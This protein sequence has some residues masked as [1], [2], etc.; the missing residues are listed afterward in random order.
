[1]SCISFSKSGNPQCHVIGWWRVDN[2]KTGGRPLWGGDIWTGIWMYRGSQSFRD[3]GKECFRQ[4][5]EQVWMLYGGNKLGAWKDRKKGR[6]AELW[7]GEGEEGG[8]WWG[9]AGWQGS[10]LVGFVAIIRWV[11]LP[12]LM[13]I[14]FSFK[15]INFLHFNH[16]NCFYM[17]QG[18]VKDKHSQRLIRLCKQIFFSNYW[19]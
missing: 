19:Q 8:R 2:V 11:L 13:S 17:W 12:K 4:R 7:E 6:V 1:M 5:E 16:R 3:L 18:A 15:N 14:T 9:Q 10:N